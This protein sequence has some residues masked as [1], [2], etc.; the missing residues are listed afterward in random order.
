[1]NILQFANLAISLFG[2]LVVSIIFYRVF[3]A[4]LKYGEEA[5]IH[6]TLIFGYLSVLII[7]YGI[8]IFLN[9]NINLGKREIAFIGVFYS[10]F[11]LEFAFFYLSLFANR[12][13]VLEKYIPIIMSLSIAIDATIV[14]LN[15]EDLINLAILLT[16]VVIFSGLYLVFQTYRRFKRT[17]NYFYKEKDFCEKDF[18]IKIKT[19]L[20]YVFILFF[21]DGIG[22]LSFF[23]MNI[24][25][26]DIILMISMTVVAF[27]TV[28]T[29][30]L[31]NKVNNI[32]KGCDITHFF[33]TLS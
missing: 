17:E 18:V 24:I 19:I 10:I 9:Q 11:Y 6:L 31:S 22:F 30:I 14:I 7:L 13:N 28:I 27:S 4:W 2:S 5:L 32:T 20:F 33:N 3:R 26:D 8:V 1:M 16:S 25:F 15:N 29:Y 12:S 23:S 21:V